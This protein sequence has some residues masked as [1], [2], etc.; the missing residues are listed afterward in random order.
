MQGNDRQS[1][2]LQKDAEIKM[3]QERE[4]NEELQQ[5]EEKKS[6]FSNTTQRWI[7][8]ILDL[9]GLIIFLG[10]CYLIQ[11]YLST[12]YFLIFML[13]IQTWETKLYKI[14]M[15]ERRDSDKKVYKDPFDFL[16]NYPKIREQQRQRKTIAGDNQNLEDDVTEISGMDETEI[17]YKPL[18]WIIFKDQNHAIWMFL[19]IFSALTLVMKGTFIGIIKN[20][21]QQAANIMTQYNYEGLEIYFEMLK[22][23]KFSISTKDYVK[24]FLPNSL[25][26]IF[27][28]FVMALRRVKKKK[29]LE[30][31][32]E[33]INRQIFSFYF[34]IIWLFLAIILISNQS[35]IGYIYFILEIIVGFRFFQKEATITQ[36]DKMVL[37]V[38]KFTLITTLLIVYFAGTPI[39]TQFV[40]PDSFWPQ[41][42]GLDIMYWMRTDY[43][44]N[45]YVFMVGGLILF[46]FLCIVTEQFTNE[47]RKIIFKDAIQECTTHYEIYQFKKQKYNTTIMEEKEAP[48]FQGQQQEEEEQEIQL[49]QQLADENELK[50]MMPGQPVRMSH[51][52]EGDEEDKNKL[53]YK[54]NTALFS[55][56]NKFTK[57]I[58]QPIVTL[59]LLQLLMITIVIMQK[60]YESLLSVIWIMIT[61]IFSLLQSQVSHYD[62]ILIPLPL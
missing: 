48:N 29:Y 35:I 7:L 47:D 26:F 24:I 50:Q 1:D 44:W 32:G 8:W 40:G 3:I 27:C 20:D 57:F 36:F 53:L 60:T 30:Q 42:F 28:C 18:Y 52:D 39:I 11:S 43:Q 45:S 19:L 49:K 21:P 59:R 61:G 5:L 22:N 56:G 10:Y 23:N 34:I 13:I 16:E 17:K 6:L 25:I 2:D 12:I 14:G 38:L 41:Y 33:P 51:V 55:L 46:A 31:F 4:Q 62:I 58:D 9:V 37:K 15:F 54:L